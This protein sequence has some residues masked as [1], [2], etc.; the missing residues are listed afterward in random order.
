MKIIVLIIAIVLAFYTSAGA[1][2]KLD[3]PTAAQCSQEYASGVEICKAIHHDPL[4][5]GDLA[6]CIGNSQDVYNKCTTG[7]R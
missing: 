2:C 1:Y 6:M 3:A 4:D 5:S 7:C